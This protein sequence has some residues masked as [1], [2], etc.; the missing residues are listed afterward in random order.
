VS[1]TLICVVLVRVV[2]LKVTT[3]ASVLMAISSCQTTSVWVCNSLY[4]C[5]SVCLCLCPSVC[6]S[7]WSTAWNTPASSSYHHHWQTPKSVAVLT[8]LH[9][10]VQCFTPCCMNHKVT[11]KIGLTLYG[12]IKTAEQQTIIQQYGDWCTGRWWV[13]IIFGTARRGLGRQW[14]R[15]VPSSLYQMWKINCR[16]ELLVSLVLLPALV[17]S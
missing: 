4:V 11:S 3:H 16:V 17:R 14:P 13:A 6:Q 10:P 2:T 12:H 5:L 7:V 1:G 15:P 8:T 9:Y